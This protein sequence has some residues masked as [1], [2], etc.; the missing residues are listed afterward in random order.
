MSIKLHR[1][2]WRFYK[3]DAHPCWR[4]QKALDARGIDYEVVEGPLRRG[5]R[6]AV[7]RL[8]GQRRYPVIELEN[9]SAFRDESKVMAAE[10]AS[11]RR[12][13]AAASN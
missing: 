6:D 9:G 12:F 13:G 2:S 10:I 11:G 8:S 7:A 4:V 1:C 5:K 3:L